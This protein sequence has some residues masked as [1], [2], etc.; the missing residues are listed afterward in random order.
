VKAE[1]IVKN[2]VPEDQIYKPWKVKLFKRLPG[3]DY[4]DLDDVIGEIFFDFKQ[5]RF[6]WNIE[7]EVRLGDD[8]E[9][10]QKQQDKEQKKYDK[11]DASFDKLE[12]KQ[13]PEG[14]SVQKSSKE[15]NSTQS[16]RSLKTTEKSG[17]ESKYSGSSTEKTSGHWQSETHSGA[18]RSKRGKREHPLGHIGAAYESR[19]QLIDVKEEQRGTQFIEIRTLTVDGDTI[20]YKRVKHKWGG[21][22][23]FKNG[24][25]SSS[26]VW[27]EEAF[28]E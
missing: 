22:F 11:V 17:Y 16:V 6:D 26:S 18:H 19:R 13:E 1:R 15:E 2:M 21:E 10:L 3:M 14:S 8:L 28:V 23:Y 4:S 9:E 5:G 25:S 24:K 27:H 7:Y 12:E 20:E